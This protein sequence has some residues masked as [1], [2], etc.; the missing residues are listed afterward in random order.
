MDTITKTV[1]LSS[2]LRLVAGTKA[3]TVD[4]PPGA[5]VADLLHALRRVS[6]ALGDHVLDSDG[7]LK[8][9]MQLLIDGRH[10]DFLQG[11][12]SPVESASELFLIPPVFGG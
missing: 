2:N 1:R 9:G 6:P 12:R 3:I 7:G 11:L 8:T 4:L 5:T 10:I